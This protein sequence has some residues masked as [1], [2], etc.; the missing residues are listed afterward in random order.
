[1]THPAEPHGPRGHDS[2]HQIASHP[3][4]AT[5]DRGAEATSAHPT[6]ARLESTKDSEDEKGS[7]AKE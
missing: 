5:S 2:E 1:M 4:P 6:E 7:E 3:E